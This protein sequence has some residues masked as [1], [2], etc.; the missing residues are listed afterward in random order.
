[1]TKVEIDEEVLKSLAGLI[2]R[3]AANITQIGMAHENAA[4]ETRN[5]PLIAVKTRARLH[6][7]TVNVSMTMV[8]ALGR[9]KRAIDKV[10]PEEA[11]AEQETVQ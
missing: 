8:E 6:Q 10:L 5:H 2:E 7:E 11:A 1:M 4:R 9:A 3:L